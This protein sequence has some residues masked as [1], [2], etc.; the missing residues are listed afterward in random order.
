MQIIESSAALEGPSDVGFSLLHRQ[1][2]LA[3]SI[4]A[5]FTAFSGKW[6][7]MDGGNFAGDLK[8]LVVATLPQSARVQGHRYHQIRV[9]VIV[10]KSGKNFC[11]Y[12]R[13][14]QLFMEFQFD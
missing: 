11:Q 3:G 9:A 14:Q 1:F 4:D 12:L 2:G 8:R 13:I 10:G 5:P 6:Y 7:L